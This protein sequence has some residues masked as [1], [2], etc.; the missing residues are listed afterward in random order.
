MRQ[1]VLSDSPE[2][3]VMW[4]HHNW[5]AKLRRLQRIVSTCGNDAAADKRHSGQRVN[6]GQLADGVEQY[7]LAWAE[8]LRR[9]R[10]SFLPPIGPSHP[11]RTGPFNQRSDCLEPLRMP[12]RKHQR[13]LRIHVQ[14]PW[15]RLQQ[16][17]FFAL[18]SAAGHDES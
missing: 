7:D 11:G 16:R 10:L 3:G 1:Q 8:R 2:V 13:K 17:S 12:R 14:Q 9:I 5:H 18:Q 4:S 15:P 6:R